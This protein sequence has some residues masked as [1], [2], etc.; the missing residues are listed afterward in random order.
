[1]KFRYL[2]DPLFL[3]CGSFYCV[4]RWLLK[5]RIDSPFLRNW[6]NDLLLIPCAIPVT[7]WLFRVLG[8]R[9]DDAAPSATELGWI[10]GFWS[11]LFEWAGPKFIIHAVGDWRDVVMYVLGAIAAW[12]YWNRGRW[13][14]PEPVISGAPANEL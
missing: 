1:V 12:A 4:N 2:R 7:F 10:L 14:R 13:K 8:L 11:I 6:C 5:P 3:L 9:G